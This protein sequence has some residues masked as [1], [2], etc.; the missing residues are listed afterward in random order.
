M[1]GANENEIIKWEE[2]TNHEFYT[3]KTKSR[4]ENKT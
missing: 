2:L 4:N 3:V 1:L